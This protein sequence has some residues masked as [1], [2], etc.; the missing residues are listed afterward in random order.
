MNNY[1]MSIP[2]QQ[3][4]DYYLIVATAAA[5][6]NRSKNLDTLE[7]RISSNM[8]II[9]C[10]RELGVPPHESLAQINCARKGMEL[11]A[12]LMNQLIRKRGH[13]LDIKA[14][15]DTYC[16]IW[17]KRRDTGETK[18]EKFTIEQAQIAG[19]IK[20]GPWHAWR[21]DMLFAR[22]MSRLSRRL[23]ADCIGSYY[24][25]GELQDKIINAEQIAEVKNEIMLMDYRPEEQVSLEIPEGLDPEKV[26]EYV[27][28][29]AKK[30]QE[31]V[32]WFK[33][34]ILEK[35]ENMEAFFDSF[36]KYVDKNTQNVQVA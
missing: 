27:E 19:L 15:T 24:I 9:L 4:L 20:P 23:F 30:R 25:E 36:R 34:K 5:K 3:E 6:V 2:T 26:E 32:Q 8:S 22:C 35:K 7:I 13:I 16:I 18:E 10:G 21:E 17:G 11:S 14:S 1:H 29:C 31:S 28:Y 12:R 33:S